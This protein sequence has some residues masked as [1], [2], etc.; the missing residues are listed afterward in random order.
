MRFG[1]PP[2]GIDSAQ[3]SVRAAGRFAPEQSGTYVFGL[4]STGPSRLLLDG[5][6]AIDNWTNFTRGGSFFGAGS[7]EQRCEI[8]LTAGQEHR[9]ELEFR[10]EPGMPMAGLRLGVMPRPPSDAMERAV[11]LASHADVAL[12]F[13]GLS[14]EWESEGF[15]RSDMDL[16]GPQNELI[17][18]VAAANPRTVVVLNA[19]S[20]VSMPWLDAVAGVLQAWYPG[21]EAGNAIAD[22]LFGDVNPSGKLP[23]TFPLRLEDNPAYLTYPG[24]NG[25]VLYGERLFVGYRYYDARRIAPLFPF[26]YGLSYTTFAYDN[27]RLRPSAV[28]PDQTLEVSIDVTNTG[29]VP[30]KEVV[31]VYVRDVEARLR[32][33][34]KELK[35]F[36]KVALEPGERTTVRLPLTRESLAYFDGSTHE[37]VAE[38]GTFEVLVGASAQDIRASASFELTETKRWL[39]P[40]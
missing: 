12:V 30:G 13:A 39:P 23:Q 3:F 27:L 9:I 28:G 1:P 36:S 7:A 26:G 21:Q 2:A 25:K 34:E 14:S 16:P 35:A 38:A 29:N 20:A 10:N 5:R 6:Q 17:E 8:E 18:R 32:R 24:E 31:Q 22:V 37:W 33:P 15:D 11:A 19:G 40:A 4:T